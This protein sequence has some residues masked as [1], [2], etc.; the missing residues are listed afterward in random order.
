[1]VSD[2]PEVQR[3]EMVALGFCTQAGTLA[4][5][6][7]AQCSLLGHGRECSLGII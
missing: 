3:E 5:S 4:A 6:V 7:K 1:M 2:L